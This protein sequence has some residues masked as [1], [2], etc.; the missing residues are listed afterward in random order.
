M[1]VTRI[2]V[3]FLASLILF[4]AENEA[5]P[6]TPDVASNEISTIEK[7][8]SAI[9]TKL[10][11]DPSTDDERI[12]EGITT[13]E[14]ED[15]PPWRTDRPSH[16]CRRPCLEGGSRM[17]CHYDFAVEWYYAMSKACYN[18]SQNSSDCF[19]PDCVPADGV[20]RTIITVNRML[21]GPSIEVCLGDHIIVDVANHL[22]EEGT[23]IHWHGHHQRGSPYMDGV[24]FISQCP[25]PSNSVFRYQF[26]A[27][28][29]G[30][31]FWHSH[32][33]LQRGD[34][35]FGSLIIRT[36][37]SENPHLGLYDQDLSEH[38]MLI[39]DWSHQLGVAMF[40]AHYHSDGDNK[41]K[42]MLV[43]GKGRYF[44]D[45]QQLTSTPLEVFTVRQ[46]VRYRFRVINA[47]VQNCPIEL[48]IDNHTLT[49]ISTD[50]S[51]IKPKIVDS[52]VSYAGERW[53]FVLTAEAD[54]GNYWMRFTGLMDC[55]ERF[56]K[57]HQVAVLHYEGASQQEPQS[58]VGYNVH[59]KRPLQLNSLNVELTQEGTLSVPHLEAM[60]TK[61]DPSLKETA[62][63]QIYL[64]FDFNAKN[65]PHYFNSKFYGFSE[66]S[67]KEKVYTPQFNDITM[68]LPHFPL[69]SQYDSIDQHTFCDHQTLKNCNT[70]FCTCTNVIHVP[71]GSVVE[72][73]LIDKGVTYNANHPF[74]LH[75]HPFRVVGMDRLGQS[76][77]IETV[78]A[79]DKANKLVRNL[80]NPAIKDTVTVPDGGYTILRVHASNP[81]YWLF[82]CHIEFHAEVGMALIFKVGEHSDFPPVPT[83][84]PRCGDYFSSP[85]NY[86]RPRSEADFQDDVQAIEYNVSTGANTDDSPV[87]FIFWRSS[88]AASDAVRYTSRISL[89]VIITTL[90]LVS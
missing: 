86:L 63:Q 46:G 40:T 67:K 33:G 8:L 55:D 54:I 7:L 74:H 5:L 53:D 71:L 49:V 34:G 52:L 14:P 60:D 78:K 36:T 44:N 57:A 1:A 61:P 89:M 81:G 19:R 83:G 18:C 50:G 73:I 48:S 76:V 51:D 47:G 22:S 30:T 21:P 66:V 28:N 25:I 87:S 56:T 42:S 23:S 84:F 9:G 6:P 16:P 41:P 32:T 31:H 82:H 43:N 77:D 75:G 17:I 10:Y 3:A 72:I 79:L 11:T 39:L 24:P 13:S 2:L 69:L 45:T 70:T 26:I 27:D 20:K 59:H 29:P 38:T 58:P 90:F 64:S 68:K 4:L 65:N 37:D 88:H 80:T 62:D 35:H 85:T 15:S 12:T